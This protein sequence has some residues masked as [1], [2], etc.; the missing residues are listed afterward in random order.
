MKLVAR[1]R[2][3]HLIEEGMRITK[4][5]CAHRCAAGQL[6]D[7]LGRLHSQTDSGDLDVYAGWRPVVA[8]RER[9]TDYSVRMVK[10]PIVKSNFPM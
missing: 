6:P 4:H 9:Q 3:R 1:C 8:E 10:F 2:L 7:E 5:H